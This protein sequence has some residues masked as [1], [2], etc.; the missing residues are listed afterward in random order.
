M[1]AVEDLRSNDSLR[2]SDSFEF[3][4]NALSPETTAV[5]IE[6]P[7]H[8]DHAIA[9][10]DDRQTIVTVGAPYRANRSRTI[11]DAGKLAVTTDLTVRNLGELSLHCLPKSS[12]GR[13]HRYIELSARACEVLLEFDQRLRETRVRPWQ[14]I[15]PAALTP[16]TSPVG[17][18][19][20]EVQTQAVEWHPRWPPPVPNRNLVPIDSANFFLPRAF[21]SNGCKP[22]SSPCS[23]P[24]RYCSETGSYSAC[25]S[26]RAGSSWRW[27]LTKTASGFVSSVANACFGCPWGIQC[28]RARLGE[29][30]LGLDECRIFIHRNS[31]VGAGN[32]MLRES[33]RS[34]GNVF[35]KE[36]P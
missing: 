15:P 4:Q 23:P 29:P 34:I 6:R 32:P 9:G 20:G 2:Q 21:A 28:R 1:R 7:I 18:A 25:R 30:H 22:S 11:D 10:D 5:S 36:N 26:S 14:K 16:P 12:A 27:S 17:P 31:S 13:G 35:D 19:S 8:R 33:S 24:S 3:Q